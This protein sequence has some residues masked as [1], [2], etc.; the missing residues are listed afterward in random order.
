MIFT[1]ADLAEAGVDRLKSILRR[2]G[3]R[4]KMHNPKTWPDQAKLAAEGRWDELDE[5]QETL[6][7]GRDT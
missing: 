2:A 7:A 5:L 1:Y 6:L 4:Y 3:D